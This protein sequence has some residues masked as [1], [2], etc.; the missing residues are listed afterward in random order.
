MGAVNLDK[1]VRKGVSEDKISKKKPE[2]N[3][4]ANHAISLQAETTNLKASRRVVTF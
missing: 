1:V 4:E 2:R 3:K